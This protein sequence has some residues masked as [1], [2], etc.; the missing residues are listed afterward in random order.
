MYRVLAKRG[1]RKGQYGTVEFHPGFGPITVHWEDGSV[2][3]YSAV[4]LRVMRNV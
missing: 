4:D 2:T 3:T 1:P